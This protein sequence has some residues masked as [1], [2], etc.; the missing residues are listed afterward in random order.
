[1]PQKPLKLNQGDT[2]GL[3]APA[4]PPRNPDQIDYGIKL[5]E[6]LGFQVKVGKY[7]RRRHGYLAGSDQQRCG[8]LMRMFS[9]P[10]I[11]AIFCFRGGHGATRLLDSIDYQVI[12]RNPKIFLG[13][14]DITS[15]HWA[16]LKKAGLVT[17]HGPHLASQFGQDTP[18]EYVLNTLKRAFCRDG[19]AG[20]I[21][22][23]YPDRA[24]TIAA[25]RRGRVTAPLIGGNLAI[26][27]NLIGTPWEVSL[28]GKILFIE[29]VGE[30]PRRIDR[31]LTFL[32]NSGRLQQVAGVA[33]GLCVDCEG[34]N[35]AVG[36][37]YQ[38][39]VFD[40]L[41]DRLYSLKVPV[42]VGLPFGHCLY[43]ATLPQGLK[44]CLDG[45]KGDLI[46]MESAVRGGS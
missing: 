29:D 37:E 12:R 39:S 7:I 10:G 45:D 28:R 22:D 21:C 17:F 8:D 42:V 15:L 35:E 33:V 1:M 3:I 41:K 14:S 32:L 4:S 2:V 24:D 11:K 44:A 19:A 5:I 43:N 6:D 23:G 46:I 30:P 26:I 27:C 36:E 16:F 31:N 9:D 34:C 18:P 40:V 25:I 38:Q 13:F 20:S